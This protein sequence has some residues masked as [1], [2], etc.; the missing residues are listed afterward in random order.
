ME[1]TTFKEIAEGVGALIAAGGFLAAGVIFLA[2][3][4]WR[5]RVQL[6]LGIDA[7]QRIGDAFLLEP[8]CIAENKGLLR[9]DIHS[10]RMSVRYLRRDDQLETGDEAILFA[11]KFPHQ[12]LQIEFIKP[13]WEWI[14]LEA[15]IRLRYS[16]VIHVPADA[17]ALLIWVKIFPGKGKSDDF[18]STQK[19]I[20]IVDDHLIGEAPTA[21]G[22]AQQI[23]GP[24]PPPASFSSK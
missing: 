19:V 6:T 15:G 3:R 13:E 11:T 22:A 8:V 16:H 14:F 2:K 12:A 4:E 1:P 21:T 17:V 23:V 24:E 5:P 9:C 10:L 18:F 7:F 20:M